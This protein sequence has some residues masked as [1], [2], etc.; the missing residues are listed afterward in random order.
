MKII[1]AGEG[2]TNTSSSERSNRAIKVAPI[3]KVIPARPSNS[4]LEDDAGNETVQNRELSE[5][6]LMQ[7][8]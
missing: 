6:A 5:E 7:Y 1:E 2:G 8:I 3:P 4:N